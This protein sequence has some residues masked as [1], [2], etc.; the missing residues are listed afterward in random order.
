VA[1]EDDVA[2]AIRAGLE[3]L[4][5]TA[6]LSQELEG[7]YGTKLQIG[8]GISTGDAVVGN[9]G[10]P[11]RMGYTAIGDTVN[12]ASRLQDLT[13][14]YASPILI[15]HSTQDEARYAFETE[16]VGFVPVKGRSE[17][18]GVYRVLGVRPAHVGG[19]EPRP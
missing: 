16:R 9:I 15:S 13:K 1:H 18:I 11:E 14:D 10:S 12:I 8:I 7:R 2:R 3:M 17:P 6:A 5:E 19:V 4:A